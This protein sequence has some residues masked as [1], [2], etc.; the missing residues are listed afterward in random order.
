MILAHQDPSL[1][2]AEPVSRTGGTGKTNSRAFVRLCFLADASSAPSLPVFLC[3]AASPQ[4]IDS[5]TNSLP[6]HLLWVKCLLCPA[7]SL[8]SLLPR[9]SLQS[10]KSGGPRMLVFSLELLALRRAHFLFLLL[11]RVIVLP[12]IAQLPRRSR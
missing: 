1:I 10:R 3:F 4:I 6:L 11:I 12:S 8:C 7:S 2:P 9:F 5:F